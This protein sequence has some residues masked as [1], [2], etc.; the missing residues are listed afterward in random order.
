[1]RPMWLSQAWDR[2]RVANGAGQVRLHHLRH[3]H[4]STL[5][6]SGVPMSNVQARGGHADLET[7]G[8]YTHALPAGDELADGVI[9]RALGQT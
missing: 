6:A 4:L 1:M 3:W 7:T 2:H 8:I 5:A 9:E